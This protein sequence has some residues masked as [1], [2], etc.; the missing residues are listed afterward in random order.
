[1]KK[2][3]EKIY[4]CSEN[5]PILEIDPDQLTENIE[6]TNTDYYLKNG[7]VENFL[8]NTES[9]K[10]ENLNDEREKYLRYILQ[11]HSDLIPDFLQSDENF[12]EAVKPQKKKKK[13]LE[14]FFKKEKN[15]VKSK[16][17]FHN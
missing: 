1:M 14:Y 16:K 5:V 11:N 4:P 3:L 15:Y 10:N 9:V 12:E 7:N 17:K 2:K 8:F 6:N 13:N